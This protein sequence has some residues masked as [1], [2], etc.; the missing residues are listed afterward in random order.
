MKL[1]WLIMLMM[2]CAFSLLAAEND[3]FKIK[4]QE[5]YEFTQKPTVTRQGYDVTIT[6]ESKG[7]CDATIAIEDAQ[8]RI[9]RHLVSGVLGPRAPQPFQ[10]DSLK[11]KVVWDG[12][13]D[14]EERITDMDNMTVRVSLGLKPAF[15]KNLMWEPKRRHGLNAPRLQ[16]TAEGVYVYDGGDNRD[17]VKL[18][19]HDGQYV[20]TIYPF[21]A[22]KIEHVKGLPH[23]TYPQ[24]GKSLPLKPT[25]HQQT[26]LT[27]GNLFLSSYQYPPKFAIDSKETEAAGEN[28]SSILAVG[29]Q[30]LVLGKTYLARLATDGS[31]G[32]LEIEGPRIAQFVKHGAFKIAI[33]PR[34]AAFSPDGKT[35]YLS[36][37][38]HYFM[39]GQYKSMNYQF[40]CVMKMDVESDERPS[41]FVG[42]MEEGKTGTDNNSFNLPACVAV[43][44]AGRV[45]VADHRNNRVQ[46]FSPDGTYLK[47]LSV[48]RPAVVSIANKSQEIYVFTSSVYNLEASNWG[49][50]EKVD[51][52]LTVFNAYDDASKKLSCKLPKGVGS[53]EVEYWYC[54]GGDSVPLSAAVDDSTSP[55][56]LW[57]AQEWKTDNGVHR[58][59]NVELYTLE[60]GQLVSKRSF[61]ADV[62]K[63]VKRSEVP[64]MGRSRLYVNPV[65]GH[66]FVAEGDVGGFSYKSFKTVLELDP[67]TAS[68]EIRPIPFD[69]EDMCFDIDGFIY[70]RSINT[71]ARYDPSNWREIPW[72][73]GE[74]RSPVH[75]SSL[76]DRKVT[77]L[78][79]GLP[80]PANGVWHHGGMYVSPKGNLVMGCGI[81]LQTSP[82]QDK[83]DLNEHG[84]AAI[85]P[86]DYMPRM[87][88]G[89][90]VSGRAG[91]PLIHIWD[92][93]GKMVASDVLPGLGGNTYGLGL[94]RDNNVY[95]MASD[96][97]VLDGKPY[98]NILT[99]TIIKVAPGK[100][101]VLS[102][103]GAPIPLTAEAQPTRPPDLQGN[104]GGTSWIDGAEWMYG[105]V[106]WDGKNAP[107]GGAC[108]C[109][110][111]RFTFD[112]F[113][114]SFAPEIDRYKIAV[115]DSNG[116]LILR[117]GQYG[118]ADSAGPRSIVPLGGDEVGIV[119]GAY[120]ATHTDRRLFIADLANDRIFSVKLDYHLTEKVQ[121]RR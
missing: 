104:G 96:T 24:D 33:A 1:I 98:R 101:K 85:A 73:Y 34:S 11:Q 108:G 5:V 95:M 29:G 45:Y 62:I 111:A 80:V 91:A 32:G 74:E 21:P 47:T 37:Y 38:I 112:Y 110:N 72:D 44:K 51:C 90:C 81:E 48:N 57:F 84:N 41:L 105:G 50:K 109:W 79:S 115:L 14:K 69:A 92:K 117:I 16:A 55:P 75:T 6:F 31:S 54:T 67:E 61:A 27:S 49:K 88:P 119:H 83:H 60:D 120:L 77:S 25:Y 10:K 17:F 89:R 42:N 107:V 43:D 36:A 23:A 106:G 56:T 97:R 100:A 118:N 28:A 87:Y 8:G 66:C 18:Y 68:I 71:V 26:F 59:P 9:V 99:G 39:D 65:N 22:D 4:R 2:P 7:Y 40:P 70:L 3:E 103:H 76:N 46:I 15:E 86:V 12:K 94:D 78:I 113:A 82:I 116:N 93:H 20:K 102:Q 30:R 19:G 63:S 114:R 52:Q 53:S 58:E 64:Q 13:N 35:L 121:L